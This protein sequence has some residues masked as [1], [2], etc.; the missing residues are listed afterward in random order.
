M[1]GPFQIAQADTSGTG[2]GKQQRIV[3]ITKPYGDQSVV[4]PLS[5]DGSVKADLSAIASEKI[6]LVH[7]GEKL[8]I[9]FDNHSTVTLEPFFD[10]TGKPVQDLTVEVSPGRDVTSA[11]FATLFP[12]TEDQSVLPA[13]GTGNGSGAQASGA[14]F[15]TVGV[16]PLALGNPLD[17]LGQEDLPG[18]TITNL[19]ATEFING[20]P[21]ALTNA[22]LTF[23]ED[24]LPGGN[25][26][27]IGDLDPATNGPISATGTL[28]HNYGPDQNSVN[29]STLFVGTGAPEGFIYTVSNGGLVLTVSQIQ[30]GASVDVLRLTLSNAIDGNY[31]IQQLHAIDH[32]PGGNENNQAFTFHYVVTDSN[33]DTNNDGT[34]ALTVNDD[35]PTVA[36]N[37]PITFDEDALP[38]GNQGGVGDYHPGDNGPITA[39]GTLAHSFGADGAGSVLLTAAGAPEGFTYSVNGA[40]TVLTVSQIQDGVSVSV[41]QIDLANRTSGNYTITQL[42]AINHAPGHDE[43]NQDFTFNYTV[44]DH[45][46]D[47]AAGTLSLT[48]NDDTP[49]ALSGTVGGK[50]RA[51]VTATAF[52]SV[53]LQRFMKTA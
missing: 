43:N 8:I 42:H 45:D 38:G 1:N 46:G 36:A 49:V 37:A 34:L 4:V 11:E 50:A 10:S 24:G 25:L 2:G 12:V 23:D 47:T 7:L 52:S 33:G 29:E 22:A 26:G 35:S 51:K 48:V 18:F 13:A 31:T 20:T 5:W 19:L 6:T 53:T 32:A 44:T 16:D 14:N 39:T 21:T 9:L 27:G 15:T 30:N 40:G 3:K 17:L 28:G 41:L